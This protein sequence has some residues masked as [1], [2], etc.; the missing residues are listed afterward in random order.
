MPD[1]I[2]L[3]LEKQ[4]VNIPSD[5]TRFELRHLRGDT[6]YSSIQI[7]AISNFGFRSEPSSCNDVQTKQPTRLHVIKKEIEWARTCSREFIDTDFFQPGVLQRENRLQ[8][9]AKL[10]NERQELDSNEPDQDTKHDNQVKDEDH[11]L[12]HTCKRERNFVYRINALKS[13]IIDHKTYIEANLALRATLTRQMATGQEK[14]LA[15][16]AEVQRITEATDDFVNSSILHGSKQQF[17]RLELYEALRTE[18]EGSVATIETCKSNIL[19]MDVENKELSRSAELK[20]EHLLERQ[21]AFVVFKKERINS[22]KHFIKVS[23]T[24]DMTKTSFDAWIGCVK[25]SQSFRKACTNIMKCRLCFLERHIL[26]HWRNVAKY[27]YRLQELKMGANIVTSRGGSML[28]TAEVARMN[29]HDEVKN[30]MKAIYSK[31]PMSNNDDNLLDGRL[32]NSMMDIFPNVRGDYYFNLLEYE[33]ALHYYKTALEELTVTEMCTGDRSQIQCALLRKCGRSALAMNA[34]NQAILY[35]E[36]LL[37]IANELKLESFCTLANLCLGQCYMHSGDMFLAKEHYI[38]SLSQFGVVD[39]LKLQLAASQGLQACRNYDEGHALDALKD[40]DTSD[41]MDNHIAKKITDAKSIADTLQA[42]IRQATVHI[43]YTVP[44][45]RVSCK[46]VKAQR[47]RQFLT[48]DIARLE[49]DKTKNRAEVERL[50]KLIANIESE[51]HESQKEKAEGGSIRR[52]SALVHDNV[53]SFE[54]DELMQ[55]L[56][57]RMIESKAHLLDARTNDNLLEIQIRNAKDELVGIM[58]DLRLEQG[59]LLQRGLMKQSIRLMALNS[60]GQIDESENADDYSLLI[61]L[62]IGK[63]V[64]VYDSVTG[65][66]LNVFEGDTNA[67]S[68]GSNQIKGH[69][70]IITSLYLHGKFIFSGSKDTTL[71][72]WNITNNQLE[73]VA[74]GH[75]ATITSVHCTTTMLISGSADKRMILWDKSNGDK[76]RELNGH[77]RGVLALCEGNSTI[78]SGDADGDVLVWDANNV[79]RYMQ[80]S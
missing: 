18:A 29:A 60:C 67:L 64:F 4:Y 61:A 35:F 51:L 63:D 34:L 53:Q 5:K 42:Q 27:Q 46:Y 22:S 55:R 45:Q 68:E 1:P 39:N 8:Y 48:K 77:S 15:L 62:T 49:K 16:R 32:V 10:E 11:N 57:S 54:G 38:T 69:T 24:L 50:P 36:H 25:K 2:K 23:T 3:R 21:A 44:F 76:L 56:R 59:E 72:C 78:V 74:K 71:R 31:S 19:L 52:V 14:V 20:G 80:Y 65:T 79:S 47:R 58:E 75:E 70:A 17:R 41:V 7:V 43:G 40:L 66:A 28:V 33:Q 26:V 37:N 73:Y 6:V 9:I 12:D 13:E 30:A